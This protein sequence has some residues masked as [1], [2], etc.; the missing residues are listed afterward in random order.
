MSKTKTKKIINKDL[1]LSKS[2]VQKEPEVVFSSKV[3]LR[4]KPLDNNMKLL[5]NLKL[6]KNKKLKK[7]NYLFKEWIN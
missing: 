7:R 6:N 5:N 2:K 4:K 3:K 1:F